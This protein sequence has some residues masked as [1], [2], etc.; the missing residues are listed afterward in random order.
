MPICRDPNLT[1]PKPAVCIPNSSEKRE[2]LLISGPPEIYQVVYG[3]VT[4]MK[5]ETNERNSAPPSAQVSGVAS[6]RNQHCLICFQFPYQ[7]E[8]PLLVEWKSVKLHFKRDCL[9]DPVHGKP[10]VLFGFCPLFLC[11]E[12]MCMSVFCT[13]SRAHDRLF[14]LRQRNV[15]EFPTQQRGSSQTD[16]VQADYF[17]LDSR[18]WG[19]QQC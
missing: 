9:T 12:E 4:A 1:Q 19:W 10:G 2:T 5:M 6:F 3:Q 14:S 13:A 7:H 16:E 15:P 18:T 11:A 8:L 17:T